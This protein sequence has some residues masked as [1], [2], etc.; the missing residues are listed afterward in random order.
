MLIILLHSVAFIYMF[1]YLT[2]FKVNAY[3]YLKKDEH[4]VSIKI[5]SQYNAQC[6]EIKKKLENESFA[7]VGTVVSS[8]GINNL[9]FKLIL[10]LNFDNIV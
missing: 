7:D 9:S 3:K 4:K 1:I 2:Y 6:S 8:Q 10:F 5:L